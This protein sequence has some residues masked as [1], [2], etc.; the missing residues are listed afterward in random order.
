MMYRHP[1]TGKWW[2]RNEP[3]VPQSPPRYTAQDRIMFG[4]S[5]A[6]VPA[7][8]ALGAWVQS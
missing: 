1:V 4:L 5:L 2:I 6:L 7:V 3:T 8:I